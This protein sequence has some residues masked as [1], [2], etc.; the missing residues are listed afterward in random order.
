MIAS[1]MKIATA[2]ERPELLG[3]ALDRTRAKLPGYNN[4]GDVLN[5]YWSHLTQERPDFQFHL[6][7]NDD[8]ILARARAIPCA[9]TARRPI[10]QRAARGRSRA[11]S[12]IAAL[13]SCAR[14]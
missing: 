12:M 4:H 6:T 10:C 7:G 3:P 5:E 1:G 14:W 9:G 13:T 11:A 8:E 2:A